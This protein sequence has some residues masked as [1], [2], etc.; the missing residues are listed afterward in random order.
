MENSKLVN[1]LAITLDD[2]LFEEF[3]QEVIREKYHT[4]IWFGKDVNVSLHTKRAKVRKWD[5]SQ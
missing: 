1:L 4:M 5:H 2:L 3:M